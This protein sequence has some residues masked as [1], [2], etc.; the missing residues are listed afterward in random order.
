M[1]AKHVKGKEEDAIR[2]KLE[3]SAWGRGIGPLIMPVIVMG[4]AGLVEGKM[5]LTFENTVGP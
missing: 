1:A 5:N 2:K 3:G 4:E